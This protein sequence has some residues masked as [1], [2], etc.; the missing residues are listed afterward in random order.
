MLAAWTHEP[1][2]SH[3][4][5]PCPPAPPLRPRG[6][7]GPAQRAERVRRSHGPRT[8][9][10]RTTVPPPRELPGSRITAAAAR[11][12]AIHTYLA[13]VQ[14]ITISHPSQ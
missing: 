14:Y 2:Y 5:A 13:R 8:H 10:S 11:R 3:T 12:A 9:A 7:A 6:R 4:V 1:T